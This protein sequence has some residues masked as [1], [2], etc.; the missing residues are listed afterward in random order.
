MSSSQAFSIFGPNW[1]PNRELKRFLVVGPG[2]ELWHRRELF[3]G[4]ICCFNLYYWGTFLTKQSVCF[5]TTKY[6]LFISAGNK[7]VV[8]VFLYSDFSEWH[9][10]EWFGTHS[11]VLIPFLSG[12]VFQIQ[13]EVWHLMLWAA[14][15]CILSQPARTSNKPDQTELRGQ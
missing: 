13:A 10:C 9:R 7:S 5:L 14:D 6:G 8:S 15:I 11:P 3:K 1:L 4:F 2:R 12:Y